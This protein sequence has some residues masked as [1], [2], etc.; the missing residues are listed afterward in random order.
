MIYL[1]RV[2]TPVTGTM[3]SITTTDI[4]VTSSP[5]ANVSA[6]T[7]VYMC[8]LFGFVKEWLK[9][10]GVPTD[11]S[12]VSDSDTVVQKEYMV[13]DADCEFHRKHSVCKDNSLL[14]VTDP[15]LLYWFT[16]RVTSHFMTEMVDRDNCADGSVRSHINTT[17]QNTMT[18]LSKDRH[19]HNFLADTLDAGNICQAT[20]DT[21]AVTFSYVD[22][23]WYRYLKRH[24]G[25]KCTYDTPK[26]D[27]DRQSYKDCLGYRFL[28]SLG[29]DYSVCKD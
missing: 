6:V 5:G 19:F 1:A 25:S 8:H 18:L 14:C 10:G 13:S 12:V 21:S 27:N 11:S 23:Y 4:A 7:L 20:N 28:K 9:E 29:F 16:V 2:N 3:D 24:G 15:E 26:T 22:C 17:A